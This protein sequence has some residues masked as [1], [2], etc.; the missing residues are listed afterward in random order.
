MT[1]ERD[2]DIGSKIK[3]IVRQTSQR[4][5]FRI[6]WNV[7][8]NKCES[9]IEKLL[10]ASFVS[11]SISPPSCI[12]WKTLNSG[13]HGDSIQDMFS[14]I[15]GVNTNMCVWDAFIVPQVSL[16]S[17][18]VDFAVFHMLVSCIRRT[19]E[20]K[21]K[22]SVLAIECDGH[23]YHERTKEQADRDRK[24][25]RCLLSANI[26]VMR[27]TGSQIWKDATAC[28]LEVDKYLQLIEAKA[29]ED[30]EE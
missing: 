7:D 19:G 6:N 15:E 30:A 5:E 28:A 8:H 27:F 11:F 2:M 16:M 10:F 4:V 1:G 18:R 29:C 13:T 9:P 3:D 22:Y 20:L 21:K 17:Y 26:P 14:F 12:R 25:D 23:D 24:R